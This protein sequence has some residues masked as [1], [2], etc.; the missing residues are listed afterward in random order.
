MDLF[1]DFDSS[2][3]SRTGARMELV[4][5]RTDQ[6][7]VS[8]GEADKEPRANYLMVKGTDS[9]DTRRAF[10]QLQNRENGKDNK[11]ISND[12]FDAEVKSVCKALAKLTVGGEVFGKVEG[13]TESDWVE[14]N[15]DNAYSLY[16]KASTFRDQAMKF[17]LDKGNY[18]RG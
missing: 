13:A 9:P 8:Q 4:N 3:K 16:I 17:I 10:M 1:S 12:D 5:P 7:I 18:I 14:M 11:T 6:V 15:E 2:E